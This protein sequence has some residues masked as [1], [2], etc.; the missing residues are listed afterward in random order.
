MGIIVKKGDLL[1]E[2]TDAIINTVN[3]VGV[4]GKGIALQFKQKWPE[5]FKAYEKACKEKKIRPGKVFVHELG[6]LA[7]KPYYI[8][9]FPTKDHWRGKSELSFIESGLK[10]LIEYIKH[11]D[12]RSISIP[13]LGCGNGGLQWSEVRTLINNSFRSLDNQIDVHLFEPDGAPSAK[14]MVTNTTKPAMTVGRSILIKLLSIY[15]EMEYS[16]SK[17]EIQK[18]CYFAQESGQLL[19]LNYKKHQFGPYADNLRHVLNA[20]NGHYITGVGDHDTSEANISLVPK[21]IGEAEEFLSNHK[22]S[23]ER[24]KRVATLIEGFE[25]PYGMELLATVHWAATR[26]V[27]HLNADNV[28]KA[29]HN[30]EPSQPLWNKRKQ[31]LMQQ[32]HIKIALERLQQE[33]W[34]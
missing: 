21:A 10:D 4:M 6:K 28:I 13:P 29:V 14:S 18:L 30:W 12:I 11:H 9:N 22:D 32:S 23:I 31:S 26:D 7:G 2:Q 17:I 20:I 1:K 16:L 25:T 3:C 33:G 5:N 15:R 27:K 19:N 8:I 24:L 34:V